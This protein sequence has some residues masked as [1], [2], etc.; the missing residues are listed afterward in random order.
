MIDMKQYLRRLRHKR[1]V[2]AYLND[3]RWEIINTVVSCSHTGFTDGAD[4]HLE[5]LGLLVRKY[6]RRK[7][8]LKL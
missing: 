3:V 4:L 5:N 1:Y 7:R 6:E 2:Q 8:W